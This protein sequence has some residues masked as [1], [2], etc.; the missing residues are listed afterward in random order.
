MKAKDLKLG[1]LIGVPGVKGIITVTVRE[2]DGDNVVVS[3]MFTF[4]KMRKS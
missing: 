4:K 3:S 1:M 2:L